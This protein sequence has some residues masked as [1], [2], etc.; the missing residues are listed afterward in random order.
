MSETGAPEGPRAR[1]GR[2]RRRILYAAAAL[3]VAAVVALLLRPSPVQVEVAG[4]DTGPL[5]V[6]VSEEGYTRLIDRYRVAA[7]V[8][9]RVL[10][11]GLE[12]GDAVRPGDVVA[13]IGSAPLDPRTGTAA[14]ARLASAEAALRGATARLEGARTAAEQGERELARRRRLE[15]AGAISPEA[16]EQ[17]AL[18]A[19]SRGRDLEAAVAA[20]HVAESELAAARAAL[21][22]AVPG[23]SPSVV[24]VRSP[25]AG[26]VLRV[27][28]PSER[29]VAAGEPLVEI[30]DVDAL[31][32]VSE[33]L[34][35]DAV[36]I[37]PGMP[38]KVEE[39]GGDR[40]LE[41]RVHSV[42]PEAI[43][44]ISPLGVEEKRVR[45][46]ATLAEVPPGLGVGY[47]VEARFI[48]W[49][50][51]SVTRIPVGALFRRGGAWR[52]FVVEGGK[53]RI[54]ELEVGHRGDDLAEVLGGLRPGDTVVLYPSHR[55]EDG[56]R[57]K[58]GS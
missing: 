58:A 20:L 5:D 11:I 26:R 45:V 30:G 39:W 57:V 37:R 8:A 42:E 48:V 23:D 19:T 31:E 41:G 49:A 4:I 53:A 18:V 50:A 15:S 47:R 24:T 51:D 34:S 54:R 38:V 9:G 27:A 6:A 16:L 52:T 21:L 17:A 10:R 22:D 46:C 44:K 2:G 25:V 33:V 7:P 29:T 43:T 13:R 36:R 35:S 1:T 40:T 3:V 55:I 12:E 32:I 56:A 14:R 28:D